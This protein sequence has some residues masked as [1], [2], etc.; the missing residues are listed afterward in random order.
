MIKLKSGKI[1]DFDP[2]PDKMFKALMSQIIDD[3]YEASN[4]SPQSNPETDKDA[5]LMK[6]IMDQCIYITHQLFEIS[7]LNKD[8]AKFIVTGFLFNSIVLSIPKLRDSLKDTDEEK[9]ANQTVH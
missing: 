6:E 1:I 7:K 8:L 9:N 5:V 2:D 3:S 4:F